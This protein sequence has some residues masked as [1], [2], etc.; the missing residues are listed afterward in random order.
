M[1]IVLSVVGGLLLLGIGYA[2]GQKPAT[3]APSTVPTATP[4]TVTPP[5]GA[6]Q[7]LPAPFTIAAGASVTMT[8]PAPSIGGGV[9]VLTALGD[10][11]RTLYQA[12]KID[13]Y[14]FY[15]SGEPLPSDGPTADTSGPTAYRY[16]FMYP[17][18]VGDVADGPKNAPLT[19]SSPPAAAWQWVPAPVPA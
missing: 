17:T 13:E 16:E 11:L 10:E 8:E 4:P 6:W 14:N 2:L 12:Q 1:P 18:N 9:A 19:L 5:A 3:P 7:A 15:P